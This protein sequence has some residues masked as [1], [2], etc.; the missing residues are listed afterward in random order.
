M[1]HWDCST[2]EAAANG[3]CE[4]D[5]ECGTSN[6]NNCE[7]AYDVY[8]QATAPPMVADYQP[9][10]CRSSGGAS[11][12]AKPASCYVS[13]TSPTDG[14]MQ[15]K[16]YCDEWAACRAAEYCHSKVGQR[17]RCFMLIEGVT[18]PASCPNGVPL[19]AGTPGANGPIFVD[20]SEPDALKFACYLRPTEAPSGRR[21]SFEVDLSRSDSTGATF[22]RAF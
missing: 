19:P 3:I 4:A 11:G 6:I 15:C 2:S 16:A 13:N 8:V 21:C 12:V 1:W 14:G 7:G 22:T 5:G 17:G 18:E 20:T 9:G 10:F